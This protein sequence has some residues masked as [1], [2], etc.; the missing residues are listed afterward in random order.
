MNTIP[1]KFITKMLRK[2]LLSLYADGDIN[3][4][5]FHNIKRAYIEALFLRLIGDFT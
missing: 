1:S 5:E 2:K 3:S 4:Q